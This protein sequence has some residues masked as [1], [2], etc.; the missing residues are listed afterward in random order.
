MA[1]LQ[2]NCELTAYLLAHELRERSDWHYDTLREDAKAFSPQ[3]E[4]F[5]EERFKH[6]LIEYRTAQPE[7]LCT[8][9]VTNLSE[10]RAGDICDD[11]TMLV[12]QRN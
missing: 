3:E 2:L 1:Q 7:I 10:F 12:L 5:G 4:K 6:M 8:E 11:I 9:I